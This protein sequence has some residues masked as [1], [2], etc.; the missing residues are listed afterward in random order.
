MTLRSLATNLM[1]S[2]VL[3]A[4]LT[5]APSAFS[6]TPPPFQMHAA[7]HTQETRNRDVVTRLYFHFFNQH[8]LA[9]ASKV[10]SE[11]FIQHNPNIGTGRQ[12]LVDAIQSLF[13][14]FPQ[15]RW[16]LAHMGAEGDLVWVQVHQT[17]GPDDRGNEIMDI[18]RL[19][20][21]IIVEHWDAGVPVS[22]TPAN[23]NTQ[24]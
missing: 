17:S 19:K 20:D 14:V 21:G 24:F 8:D 11:D 13:Q 9:Y 16:N 15:A 23:A 10:I 18:Y 7:A 5:V 4:G 12:P 2:G 3:L 6:Q 22:A 1:T